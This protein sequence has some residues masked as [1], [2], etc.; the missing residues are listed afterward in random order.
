[1]TKKWVCPKCG[2][3]LKASAGHPA[4]CGR[5]YVPV[6]WSQVN[7]TSGCWLWTGG[8]QNKGYGQIAIS[9]ATP[10]APKKQ[11][12]VLVHR[13]SWELAYGPVPEG[14]YVLHKCDTPRCVRPDH[15]ALG[16]QTEN[17]HDRHRK[18]RSAWGEKVK[19]NKLTEAQAR[20]ILGLKGRAEARALAEKYGV[21]AGAITAIWRGDAWA[22]LS[23]PNRLTAF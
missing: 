14:M 1:M 4:F 18:G 22:R 3:K 21:G 13:Y 19:R 16:T 10:N 9:R 17:N 2:K 20:E 12:K 7:K 15:L 5:D 6:F 8:V 11:L 23:S